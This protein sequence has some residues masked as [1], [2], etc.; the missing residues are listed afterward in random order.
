[1]C[2][3]YNPTLHI[4]VATNIPEQLLRLKSY[5]VQLALIIKACCWKFS[6]GELFLRNEE[7]YSRGTAQGGHSSYLELITWCITFFAAQR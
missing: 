5:S 3:K 4:L 6:E 2:Y 7:G 1:M